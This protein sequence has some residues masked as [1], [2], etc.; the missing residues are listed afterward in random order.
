MSEET[1]LT[2]IKNKLRDFSGQ[3]MNDM[4]SWLLQQ[5]QAAYDTKH[6]FG[7][8]IYIREASVPAGAV[9]LGHA[10][11]EPHLAV[12]LEGQMAVL[13]DGEIT[14]VT[15]PATFLSPAGRKLAYIME[16]L[17]IQNI[18]ATDETDID[19]LEDMLVDKSEAWKQHELEAE[20]EL[21]LYAMSEEA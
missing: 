5:P 16:D 14:V 17:I 3:T 18:F 1:Q 10:H 6:H 19:K 11:K 12:V 7:P 2:V 4:E 15:A 13:M 20:T 9:V 21:L 8:N